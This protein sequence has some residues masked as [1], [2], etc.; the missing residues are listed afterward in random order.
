MKK[1]I[2]MVLLCFLSLLI[3]LS[4]LNCQSAMKTITLTSGEAVCD[5]N[6]EWNVLV[7]NYGMLALGGS[8][9]QLNKITQK[10]SSFV[11]IRMIDDTYNQ[12]GSEQLRGELDKSGF[13][14][15]TIITP[16]GSLPAKGQISDNGN[17]MII[18]DGQ[19]V[20]LTYTRKK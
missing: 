2:F 6:G 1:Q 15:V 19:K 5:L 16:M 11:G 20:E 10:G 14:E 8:Y 7:E 18:D 4:I 9:P 17:K 12:K 13:K 3:I